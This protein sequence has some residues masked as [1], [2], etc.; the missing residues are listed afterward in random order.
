MR[1]RAGDN[2]PRWM[3]TALYTTQKVSITFGVDVKYNKTTNVLR[4][5]HEGT[6]LYIEIP[7]TDYSI[8]IGGRCKCVKGVGEGSTAIQYHY[9]RFWG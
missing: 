7:V 4:A 5:L 9:G 3:L 6:I 1:Y 2:V 8:P